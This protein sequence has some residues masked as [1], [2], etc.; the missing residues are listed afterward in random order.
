MSPFFTLRRIK[1]D[2]MNDTAMNESQVQNYTT[3]P[4][5]TGTTAMLT[6]VGWPTGQAGQTGLTGNNVKFN[7]TG[8]TEVQMEK[9][10]N[11]NG[12]SVE[13]D[14]FGFPKVSNTHHGTLSPREKSNVT[15]K[16]WFLS[17]EDNS[18]MF[19]VQCLH[20]IIA[21]LTGKNDS[22]HAGKTASPKSDLPK[23]VDGQTTPNSKVD[24]KHKNDVARLGLVYYVLIYVFISLL[25]TG[26]LSFTVKWYR[27]RRRAKLS[28]RPNN[29]Q[30]SPAVVFRA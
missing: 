10:R 2:V 18:T 28:V 26:L 21:S 4:P 30:R 1:R 6:S 3:A 13:L 15:Q 8:L 5:N 27:G 12:T 20:E 29:P 23:M 16:D 11:P 22:S 14:H 9:I 25:I 17:G 7:W 24:K 19:T